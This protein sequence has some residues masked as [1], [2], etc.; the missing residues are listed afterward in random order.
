MIGSNLVEHTDKLIDAAWLKARGLEEALERALEMHSDDAMMRLFTHY[1]GDEP[2]STVLVKDRTYLLE[3]LSMHHSPTL[4]IPNIADKLMRQTERDTLLCYCPEYDE[5]CISLGMP[6]SSV[7]YALKIT[8]GELPDPGRFAHDVSRMFQAPSGFRAFINKIWGK[9][10]VI[11]SILSEGGFFAMLL[12]EDGKHVNAFISKGTHRWILTEIFFADDPTGTV[13][14]N[15]FARF[16]RNLNA[17]LPVG[18]TL[19]YCS[20]V[21]H[22]GNHASWLI[23]NGWVPES[24]IYCRYLRENQ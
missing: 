5:G 24:Y 21:N 15:V 4:P 14:D 20:S 6:I 9:K 12:M 22:R 1:V 7:N 11:E 17:S 8:G 16:I 23:T 18:D 19:V 10:D 3:I 2:S 13:P